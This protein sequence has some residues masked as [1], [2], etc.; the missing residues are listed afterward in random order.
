MFAGSSLCFG[1]DKRGYSSTSRHYTY[2]WLRC[3]CTSHKQRCKRSCW[4][5]SFSY[6]N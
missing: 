2:I 6:S 5:P 4:S 1:S 3:Q